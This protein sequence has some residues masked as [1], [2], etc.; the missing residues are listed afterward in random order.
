MKRCNNCGWFNLDTATRCEMCDEEG[1][2]LVAVQPSAAAEPVPEEPHPVVTE[3]KNPM[4]ATVAFG[5]DAALSRKAKTATVMDANAVLAEE[6]VESVQCP[7]CCY[8]VTADME[9]CPIC[10][11]TIRKPEVKEPSS[12]SEY[13]IQKTVMV[14]GEIVPPAKKL[15]KGLK[16]KGLK[17]TVRDIPQELIVEDKEVFRLVPVDGLGEAPIEM[18]LDD[19]VVISGCRY[20]FQK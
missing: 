2:E 6:M 12:V 17:A 10:G 18:H 13:D 16:F 14:G 1:L 11:T 7:K 9:F 20:K 15:P 19:I 8:P 5:A 4:K 3:K